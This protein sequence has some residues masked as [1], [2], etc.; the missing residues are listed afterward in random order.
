MSTAIASMEWIFA[1]LR[2]CPPLSS[3]CLVAAVR[4]DDRRPTHTVAL[5][6]LGVQIAAARA[7]SGDR[8]AAG[9]S[10]APSAVGRTYSPRPSGGNH[11]PTT[12]FGETVP[13]D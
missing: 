13:G 11:V 8:V 9:R 3:R 7:R 2:G 6:R 1:T 10:S 5:D 12:A 4:W